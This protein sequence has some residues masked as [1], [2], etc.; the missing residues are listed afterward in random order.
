MEPEPESPTTIFVPDDFYCPISGE[1]MVDPVSDPE[2]H[3]YEKSQIETWLQTNQ[4]SPMTR[5]PLL[6]SD[7]TPNISM[8]KSIESI[9]DK[10]R[11]DQL[12]KESKIIQEKNIH[13]TNKLREINLST[14]YYN[15]KL[16]VKVHMPEVE[17][18]EP[19]DIVV[20]LDVS[21]SMGT[22]ATLKQSSGERTGDGF[23]VLSLTRYA[24][25]AILE[26]LHE[27]DR[28]SLVTFTSQAMVMI[29]LTECTD[30][31][32]PIIKAQ[33]DELKPLSSTNL[34]DGIH[35]SLEEL[36]K[37]SPPEKLKG[38]FVLTD[39]V[40]NVEPP[41][42]HEAMLTS[43][44][45]KNPRCMINTYGFGYDIK[46][47]LLDMISRMS[48]G[49]YSFIPDA[50]ILANI[51]IQGVSNFYTMAC[52]GPKLNITV[53]NGL[54]CKN[55][56]PKVNTLQ[57]GQ[58]RHILIDIDA[59]KQDSYDPDIMK[60]SIQV[61]LDLGCIVKESNEIS[62]IDMD[63]YNEQYMRY[64]MIDTISHCIHKHK[65]GDMS[66]VARITELLTEMQSNPDLS[67]NEYIMNLFHTFE[68]QVREAF[69]MTEEGKRGYWF[70]KWGKDYLLSL[71]GALENELCNNFRDKAV[72]NFGGELFDTLRD[73][74]DTIFESL[75]P[76]KQ[77]VQYN[78]YYSRSG[79]VSRSGGTVSRSGGTTQSSPDMRSYNS[80]VGPCCAHGSLVKMADGSMKKVEEL[81]KGDIVITVNESQEYT[82][83]PIECIVKTICNENMEL[84]VELDD[85]KIT[86]YHP[87]IK[88]GKWVHPINHGISNIMVCPYL[89]SF[90]IKNRQSIVVNNY[91]FATFGHG[92]KGDVIE[93]D[94][95]GTNMVIN[96]LREF[97]T[98]DRGLVLLTKNMIYRTE[99]GVFKIYNHLDYHSKM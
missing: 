21:G 37:G 88:D 73:E 50:G 93:H 72:S 56:Q 98:Y 67:G 48:G 55:K 89:Y 17:V 22:E 71:V 28:F 32:K 13:F 69:N 52:Y 42:G 83:S 40:P 63:C 14:Y 25:N 61:S 90:V 24:T 82:K 18:R 70:T 64:K 60:H 5:S 62:S 6:Q 16:L 1:L 34:W 27:G 78:G 79:T 38:I 99:L 57:Y 12:K 65:Y 49:S 81:Q 92:L 44:F 20:C 39:G 43:Y 95:F 86:P 85:L 46:S 7:L 2:G 97:T 91:T 84:L 96:D 3:T 77:D 15:N 30:I 31:N 58:D 80:S 54:Q 23:S 45:K 68:T 66:Y 26:T 41:R 9:R 87:I 59:Y 10:L 47:E 53:S 29:P 74:M 94:Y 75:D 11:E 8:R 35:K 36:R 19:V 33:L 4:T 76:P 51:L